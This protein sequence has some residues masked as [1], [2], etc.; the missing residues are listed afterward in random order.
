MSTT[1]DLNQ[2]PERRG[3]LLMS[4]GVRLRLW[5]NA[6]LLP[7]VFKTQ[8]DDEGGGNAMLTA[9]DDITDSSF[10]PVTLRLNSGRV[11]HLVQ[12]DTLGTNQ[13]SV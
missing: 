7:N 12:V 13:N 6:L 8:C 3:P 11:Q 1:L 5:I 10:N 9:D 4:S 2:E